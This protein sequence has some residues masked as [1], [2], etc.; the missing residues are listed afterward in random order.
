MIL[1]QIRVDLDWT[2]GR[3]SLHRNRFPRE[4]VEAL[5]LEISIV[6]LYGNVSNLF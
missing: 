2:L 6:R 1:N 3:I 5:N 4:V